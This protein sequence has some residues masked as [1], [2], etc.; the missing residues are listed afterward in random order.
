M[1]G[2]LAGSDV[3][4]FQNSLVDL[5]LMVGLDENT[6]LIPEQKGMESKKIMDS[7]FELKFPPQ[8][9]SAVSSNT[10]MHF[11]PHPRQDFDY[12]LQQS[13]LQHQ[14]L[15]STNVYHT[16]DAI[17]KSKFNKGVHQSRIVQ[18]STSVAPG[19]IS[20]HMA[21]RRP[22]GHIKKSVYA[23]TLAN[24]QQFPIP[25][26]VI[27]SIQYF[28][29][30]DELQIVDH[31]AETLTHFLVLT[32]IHGDKTYATC[33]TFYRPYIVEKEFDGNLVLHPDSSRNNWTDKS[34]RVR[35][36]IPLCCVLISKYPYFETMKESLS[37]M[38]H[39]IETRPDDMYTYI[40]LFSH[41]L[42][43]TPTPPAG[44][45]AIEYSI[46]DVSFIISPS[47]EAEKQVI[48]IPLYLPFLIFPPDEIL[49]IISAILVEHRIVFVASN[50][51]L[52]TIVMESFLN[53]ILPFE[54]KYTYVPIL[55]SK[56]LELLEAPGTFMMGCHSKYKEEVTQVGGLVMV[57][58]DEGLLSINP[59]QAD[60]ARSTRSGDSD[61]IEDLLDIPEIPEGAANL[62]TKVCQ[63]AKFQFDLVDV[64][65]PSYFDLKK[66][67]SFR[68]RKIQT[69]NDFIVS[70]CLELM[71]NLFRS[72]VTETRVEFKRFNK[73]A[74][75]DSKSGPEKSFYEKVLKTSMFKKF[76]KDRINDKT[77]YWVKL[78]VKTRPQAKMSD[79]GPTVPSRRPQLRK[80]SSVAITPQKASPSQSSPV[81]RMP[82]IGDR[83][84]D[85][86][87]NT[88]TCL[89]TAVQKS[90]HFQERASY[91]YLLGMCYL[92][93]N[94]LTL[95]LENF[96]SLAAID[97]QILP[98]QVVQQI[99]QQM[100]DSEVQKLTDRPEFHALPD[101][102]ST[103]TTETIHPSHRK[104]EESINLPEKDLYFD[105]FVECVSVLEMTSDT[106]TIGRLFR[107]LVPTQ[108]HQNF[109][110][111]ETFASFMHC[112]KEN[113]KQCLSLGISDEDLLEAECVLKVSSL[114]KTDYGTGRVTLTDRRLCFVKDIS[115]ELKEITRLS[116]IAELEKKTM[117][118]FLKQVKVLRI[119]SK[120]GSR[121]TA[122]L[123]E[124]R[125]DFCLL[126]EEMWAGK[127]VCESTKDIH[128]IQKA[129]QNVLLVDAVLQSGLDE[130]TAHHG[131][132]E[133]AARQLCF[134]KKYREEGHHNVPTETKEVL[135]NRIDPNYG[136]R[137][138]KTVHALLY[139]P[140][141]PEHSISPRLWVGLGDGKIKVYNA[142]HWLLESEFVQTKQSVQSSRKKL[143][144]HGCTCLVAVDKKHVWAGSYGIFIIDI[145]TIRSNKTLMDHQEIVMDIVSIDSGRYAF[146]ASINGIIMKWDVQK[147][148]QAQPAI[149][150]EDVR[151]L[152]SIK[153]YQG[154][155]WC[156]T[157]QRI[158]KVNDSG[159]ILQ[160][161][162]F[163]L[164]DPKY[165]PVE[166]DCFLI[167]EAEYADEKD[168]IWAGCRREG[169]ILIWEVDSKEPS[170]RIS[171]N[172][173][174]ISDMVIQDR[175][176]WAGSKD[177]QIYIINSE[178][179]K[180]FRTL[181]AH[182]DAVRSL[183][184][185][186][187]RYILSGSGS[188]D[189]KIAIW[190]PNDT[191]TE[192]GTYLGI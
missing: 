89:T 182:D 74:Y 31:K 171:I 172:C 80:Q 75:L 28:C 170:R 109:I 173:R 114:C 132:R 44:R 117:Y 148:T 142:S 116:K 155:I 63:K 13:D 102:L 121:F 168:E 62:F 177:G 81:F 33:I 5:M 164:V 88:I 190:T 129:A 191:R 39:L 36:F 42:T 26:E 128:A 4:R 41:K 111:Q 133:E 179:K 106:D 175:R 141:V 12:P 9:L 144:T 84:I 147:L 94:K 151:D 20:R 52:L 65:R 118:S 21:T 152:R 115:T 184:N 174:G 23:S 11:F 150:L 178:T 134:Y 136:E 27:K 10:M 158:I 93:C 30:P 123:K 32:N 58:I 66:E 149:R 56:S 77:D 78:E 165:R 24:S 119:K 55:S 188:S 140:G 60:D 45:V 85:Y 54:W 46:Q 187:N 161:L 79:N 107:A 49:R 113:N 15:K 53:Y 110:D 6:G 104:F 163:T 71:V 176:V 166:M 43:M 157:W 189:G 68:R 90:Q 8:V 180:P 97:A 87:K 3:M 29:F 19:S 145:E 73:Q 156:G 131:N 1:A 16:M 61:S 162:E 153:Y 100:A 130:E 25:D 35:C 120:E 50:Y 59:E 183:C 92:A 185:A 154:H 139:T 192:S 14:L 137:E 76:L 125:D 105:D 167:L 91:I 101:L 38:V 138:R 95:A 47:Q 83:V 86:L 124:E 70:G 122:W 67:R 186:E 64:Q 160:Q 57:D 99:C 103:V 48:D 2:G 98:E 108:I 51:A 181:Q 146:T 72:V 7:L 96:I 159:Q 127:I 135:Q 169:E 37:Y 22:F 40:K 34:N 112:W 82:D 143:E 17:P 18:R 126:I 69:L